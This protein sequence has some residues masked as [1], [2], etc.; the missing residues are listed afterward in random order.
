MLDRSA[1]RE[2]ADQPDPHPAA[3]A[4]G[5]GAAR[6][7]VT[8]TACGTPATTVASAPISQN[9]VVNCSLRNAPETIA[10]ISDACM[11]VASRCAGP[12]PD[13]DRSSAPAGEQPP[14]RGEEADEG[15]Q[16]E[17]R[18]S[19]RA[20]AGRSCGRP[21]PRRAGPGCCARSRTTRCRSGPARRRVNGRSAAIRTAPVHSAWRAVDVRV[22]DVALAR[23]PVVQQRRPERE[24]ER[25]D[26]QQR[27][28]R[29]AGRRSSGT[30]RV[31]IAHRA[32]AASPT[33]APR[34]SVASVAASSSTSTRPQQPPPLLL[35]EQVARERQHAGHQVGEVVRV[36]DRP[37]PRARGRARRTR[38]GPRPPASVHEST[39]TR[40][41][42]CTSLDRLRELHDE[43]EEHDEQ[44]VAQRVE[45][46][47][48]RVGRERAARASDR[49]ER[50]SRPTPAPGTRSGSRAQRARAGP[51]P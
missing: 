44:R 37:A 12:V 46:P 4:D 7:P 32:S 50:R 22:G 16:A 23:Q 14:R 47:V 19:R 13:A 36:G 34:D 25:R 49:E 39:N 26:A 10:T 51:R 5:R 38:R 1:P 30:R 8:R 45:H 20:R 41:T 21:G 3:A 28:R 15:D 43:E 9:G 29:R 17:Q 33:S 31:T 40:T 6:G 11:A 24:R 2:R 18:R 27:R 35:G 42:L 48:G